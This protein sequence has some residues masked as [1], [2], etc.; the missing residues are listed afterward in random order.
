MSGV[1]SLFSKKAKQPAPSPTQAIEK[2]RDTSEM[3]AKRCTYLETRI[4]K[5]KMNAKR[6]AQKGDRNGAMH[7]LKIKKALE[8]QMQQFNGTRFTL[9]QQILAIESGTLI[10]NIVNVMAESNRTMSSLNRN[11]DQD[12]VADILDDIT[13]Q[14]QITQDIGDTLS[15]PI[16]QSFDDY[17]LENELDA[18]MN[19]DLEVEFNRVP[20]IPQQ[21]PTVAT[22]KQ[23]IAT[24]E[25]D[26]FDLLQQEFGI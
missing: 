3:I 14:I 7:S 15:S 17:E 9:E 21:Q 18:L 6:L 22:P 16:G 13:D 20:D 12:D 10:Y 26:E 23:P 5:E 1:M 25:E 19:E 4:E 24:E 8:N 2:L 11:M